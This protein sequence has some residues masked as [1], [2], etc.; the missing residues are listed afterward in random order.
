[1]Q[2]ED[3]AGGCSGR[4]LGKDSGGEKSPDRRVEECLHLGTV[5]EVTHRSRDRRRDR[6]G[7]QVAYVQEQPGRVVDPTGGGEFGGAGEVGVL[8]RVDRL[9]L[10][11]PSGV[12]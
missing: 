3:G 6:F 11:A 2:G 8:G 9:E 12:T 7:E 4:R 5:V 1:M 10:A